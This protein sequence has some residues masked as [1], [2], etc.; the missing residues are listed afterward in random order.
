MNKYRITVRTDASYLIGAE[1]EKEAV[2]QIEDGNNLFCPHDV[3]RS[4]IDVKNLTDPV[5]LISEMMLRLEAL[6]FNN[7]MSVCKFCAGPEARHA[8]DCIIE[9]ASTYLRPYRIRTRE[10]EK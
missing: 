7:A 3:S 10:K 9:R 6:A 1:T 5:G 2:A 8:P 4:V